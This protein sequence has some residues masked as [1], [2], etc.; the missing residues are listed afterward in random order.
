ML[1][2]PPLAPEIRKQ[3][4]LFKWHQVFPLLH[5]C[6]NHDTFELLLSFYTLH[7]NPFGTTHFIFCTP[8]PMLCRLMQISAILTSSSKLLFFLTPVWFIFFNLVIFLFG[9]EKTHVCSNNY[10]KKKTDALKQLIL[11]QRRLSDK[12]A[13]I[14]VL[15]MM[16]PKGAVVTSLRFLVFSRGKNTTTCFLWALCLDGVPAIFSILGSRSIQI[17]SR[18]QKMENTRSHIWE[19][20]IWV[21]SWAKHKR[22]L[23]NDCS[24]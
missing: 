15:S 3:L 7:L 1:A 6:Y 20:W 10:K 5:W 24:N 2:R 23:P 22:D 11:H 17:L 18:L 12:Q 9:V 14:Y 13:N 16:L 4:I 8:V 19:N 21:K